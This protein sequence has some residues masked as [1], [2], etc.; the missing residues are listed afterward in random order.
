MC[1]HG[2]SVG[3]VVHM[4]WELTPM[5]VTDRRRKLGTEQK[6]GVYVNSGEPNWRWPAEAFSGRR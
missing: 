2:E 6:F 5:G 3:D 4:L 1:E